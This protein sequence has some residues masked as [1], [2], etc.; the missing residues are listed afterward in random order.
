MPA[1]RGVIR[2]IK[3]ASQINNF[4]D[5]LRPSLISKN[6]TIT[7]TDIDGLIDYGG[8]AFVYIEGK[9]RTKQTEQGQRMALENVISSHAKAG[10]PA[11]AVIFEHDTTADQ[12]VYVAHCFVRGIY[13]EIQIRSLC[14]SSYGGNWWWPQRKN[15]KVIEAIECFEKE[16]RIY[17]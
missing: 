10:H 3:R 16:F 4:K 11:M 15:I 2:N 17:Q 13:C 8:R 12:Q 7:P 9:M 14:G 1:Q 6:K 5:L